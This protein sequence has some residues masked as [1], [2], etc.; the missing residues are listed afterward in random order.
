MTKSI[1]SIIDA[2]PIIVLINEA[3][4]G[5][6]TKENCIYLNCLISGNFDLIN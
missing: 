6:S 2:P 5:Q 3:C 4:P 1:R